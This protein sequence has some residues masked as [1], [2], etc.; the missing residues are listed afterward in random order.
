MRAGVVT[1]TGAIEV[2]TVADPQPGPGQLVLRVTSCGICGSDLKSR[3]AMP[4]GTVMGHEFCGQVVA[5]GEPTD[6]PAPS[7]PWREGMAA[8]V[9]P[10][11]SC[12][13]CAWCRVGE[14][15]HCAAARLVGLGGA[16]GGF[17]EYVTA[18]RGAHLRAG[19]RTRTCRCWR[20]SRSSPWPSRCTT[21]LR[22]SP[23]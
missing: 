6:G 17:A 12:G 20:C 23:R 21:A 5:V 16:P 15:A 10:V 1:D 14:V 19:S 22:S 11:F 2:E 13:T 18:E 3:P 4:H 7:H 9:L 8:A